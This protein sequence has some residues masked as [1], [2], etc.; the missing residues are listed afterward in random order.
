M[1]ISMKKLILA[2]ALIAPMSAHAEKLEADPAHSTITFE[3]VHLKVSKIPGRFTQ[4][5]GTLDLNE[6][7]PTK[8]IVD[9]T[10]QIPSL[11]TAVEQRDTHLK[12]PDFFDAAK[13]PTATFKSTSIKRDGKGY[14]LE[15]DLTIR[16]VTKKTTFRVESL[17]RVEDPVMKVSK[18]V[19]HATGE[20]NRKD[21]GV[22]YG[23]DAIVSD[24]ISLA[25]NL[26]AVP[27]KK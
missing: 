4:F 9:F 1:K 17:G 21:F 20:I 5:N 6:K 12:S 16:G 8:S 19:F 25:V 15:G 18:V 11:T 13:Y 10:V 22:S 23:P 26:E 2:A 3:A 27:A 24:I 14:K 7:D